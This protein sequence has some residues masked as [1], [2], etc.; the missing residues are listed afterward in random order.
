MTPCR[1]VYLMTCLFAFAVASSGCTTVA[2]GDTFRYGFSDVRPNAASPAARAAPA[3]F[4]L[5]AKTWKHEWRCNV[6]DTCSTDF[7]STMYVFDKKTGRQLK[8]NRVEVFL[9]DECDA[10][11]ADREHYKT[12][13][14]TE[15]VSFGWGDKRSGKYEHVSAVL[16]FYADWGSVNARVRTTACP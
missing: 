7:L 6:F 13:T 3:D 5:R 16:V 2:T 11:L 1:A 12:V 15:F 4:Q 14:D 9:K 8:W 10:S